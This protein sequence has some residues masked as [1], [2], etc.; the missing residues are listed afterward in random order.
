MSKTCSTSFTPSVQSQKGVRNRL[1]EM[2]FYE[3][4][5]FTNHCSLESRG[6]VSIYYWRRVSFIIRFYRGGGG[7]LISGRS[8]ESYS[9]ASVPCFQSY[10]DMTSVSAVILLTSPDWEFD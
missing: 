1:A 7:P 4:L 10:L 9:G 8:Y 3:P 5:H 2:N 6:V